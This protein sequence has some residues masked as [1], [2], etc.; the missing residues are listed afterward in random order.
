MERFLN[1][2]HN[3]YTSSPSPLIATFLAKVSIRDRSS[4]QTPSVLHLQNSSH[5]PSWRRQS[6]H[7]LLNPPS[8]LV[9][10]HFVVLTK[11]SVQ[12]VVKVF[13]SVSL[14]HGTDYC[15]GDSAGFHITT[16]QLDGYIFSCLRGIDA[17]SPISGVFPCCSRTGVDLLRILTSQNVIAKIRTNIRRYYRLLVRWVAFILNVGHGDPNVPAQVD[18]AF[19]AAEAAGSSFKLAWYV[20]KGTVV[21]ARFEPSV[22][23]RIWGFFLPLLDILIGPCRCYLEP[24][25]RSVAAK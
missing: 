2:V 17:V 15:G 9:T 21:Q 19:K 18:Y 5:P 16:C 11:H 1:S 14:N 3:I 13:Q 8:A 25:R 24:L 23:S 20:D 22:S 10:H 12:I 6:Y 4:H 7:Q